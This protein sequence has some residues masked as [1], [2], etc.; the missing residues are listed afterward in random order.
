MRRLRELAFVPGALL[1]YESPRRAVGSLAA[2]AEV[3][4]G[5]DVA[6]CR[7]LTKLHEEVLRASAPALL[8][9]V[10]ARE[11]L[12]GE[13]VI[14]VAPPSAE[15]LAAWRV[16]SGAALG[17]PASAEDRDAALRTDIREALAAGESV[18]AIA[19]R[20]SQKHSLKKRTVYE[21]ALELQES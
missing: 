15:E 11:E 10:Q 19:K 3:F 9:E 13:C 16:G 14:V 7:E 20:L 1:F 6:L 2:V 17:A 8:D 4:P 12:R 18:S 21:L 5:R